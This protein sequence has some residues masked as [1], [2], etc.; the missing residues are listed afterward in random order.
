MC[1]SSCSSII[2]KLMQCWCSAGFVKGGVAVLLNTSMMITNAET[3][4]H[5]SCMQSSVTVTSIIVMRYERWYAREQLLKSLLLLLAFTII[6]GDGHKSHH[7]KRLSKSYWGFS[8]CC[9]LKLML[10]TTRNVNVLILIHASSSVL[11]KRAIWK[12]LWNNPNE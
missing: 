10:K 9:V 12:T 6:S 4:L 1:R 5:V 11:S 8:Y 7:I 2:W 3:L